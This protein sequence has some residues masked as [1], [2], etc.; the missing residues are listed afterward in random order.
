MGLDTVELVLA[1]EKEFGIAIDD[2]DAAYLSTPRLLAEYIGARL[3]LSHTPSA[4]NLSH[5]AFHRIRS[6][7][8]EQFGAKRREVR[9]DARIHPW[10]GSDVRGNWHALTEALGAKHLPPLQCRKTIYYPIALGLPLLCAAALLLQDAP[11]WAPVLAFFF[12]WLAAHLI[13]DRMADIVPP[14]VNTV[15]GLIPHV[16]PLPREAWTH[17]L[18]L[19]RIMQITATHAGRPAREIHPDHHFVKDLCLG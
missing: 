1:I 11:L 19:Q 7:L 16:C 8:I 2:A 4:T 10:L 13:T 5:A 15:G 12:L 9:L 18:V 14:A 17:D 3:G 6:V